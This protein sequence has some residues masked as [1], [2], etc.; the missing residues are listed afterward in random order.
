M[1][2][3]AAQCTVVIT[4]GDLNSLSVFELSSGIRVLTISGAD[5]TGDPMHPRPCAFAGAFA[6]GKV[7][8]TRID[9]EPRGSDWIGRSTSA[10]DGNIVVTLHTAGT[11]SGRH[12]VSGTIA[13][14]ATSV[15]GTPAS[16]ASHVRI[17]FDS[18][19]P[20]TI[21]GGGETIG[22][23]V[24][25][26]ITGIATFIDSNGNASRCEWLQWT[27]QPLSPS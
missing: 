10:S 13:G 3:A 24:S 7:V 5:G 21:D 16:A 1:S 25:G 26:N 14:S 20:Q 8:S 23:F 18:V 22:Q 19:S 15:I 12:A 6:G 27:L 4:S 11:T 9:L 17:L 2:L